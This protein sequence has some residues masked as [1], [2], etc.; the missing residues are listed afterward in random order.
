MKSWLTRFLLLLPLLVFTSCYQEEKAFTLNPDG[1]G[2]V[3][4]STTFPLEAAISFVDDEDKKPEEKLKDAA[5]DILE[6]SEGVDAW[7]DVS[8]KLVDGEKIEFH[9]TAY[10]RDLNRLKLKMGSISSS[11]LNPVLTRE[12][13][14]VTIVCGDD[15]EEEGDEGEPKTNW[16]ELSDKEKEAEL[17]KAKQQIV[18][19][20]AMAAGLMAGMESK[21]SFKLPTAPTKH[22]NFKKLEDMSYSV[23]ISGDKM[24]KAFDA[25]AE[26][27]ELLRSAVAGGMDMQGDPPDELFEAM[28]GGPGQ[29]TLVYQAGAAPAFD[30]KSE[31]KAAL[32]SSPAMM[33]KLGLEIVPATP[34]TDGGSFESLRLA[35]LRIVTSGPTDDVR[36]FNWTK[37]TSLALIA[38]LPGAVIGVEEG[39]VLSFTLDNGQD[40]M[41]SKDWDR[42][43]S[44]ADLSEDGTVVGFEVKSD[45]LP[46]ADAKAIKELSGELVFTASTG[47][48]KIDLGFAKL[49]VGEEGAKFGAKIEELGEHSFHE[50][51]LEVSIRFK[52]KRE[53]IKEV[54]FLNPD[55]V[56]LKSDR[57]GYSWGGDEGTMTFTVDKGLTE[58]HR[59]EIETFAGVSRHVIPFKIE[60]TPLMP[61]VE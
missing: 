27:E 4:F 37:G 53:M 54:H 5:L 58:K 3:K 57:N 42:D 46:A 8:F 16:D 40:L 48:E 23:E 9:G 51:K 55:G 12:G 24:L 59:V 45:K 38:K 30:Y 10:F 26:D 36:P 20:K 50:D 25:L 31:L 49:A 7:S 11:S 44:G 13:D 19:M 43:I 14:V 47:T 2:K 6:E 17:A 41:S 18:Q 39:K 35:G 29:P 56:K 33:K 22:H 60:N 28:F 21:L 61:V 32:E 15:D 52:M 34:M 1:S